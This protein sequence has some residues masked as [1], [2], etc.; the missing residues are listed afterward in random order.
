MSQ[1]QFKKK[2]TGNPVFVL[3]S[4]EHSK[5][6]ILYYYSRMFKIVPES[7]LFI[8]Y[9]VLPQTFEAPKFF[10]YF[11]IFHWFKSDIIHTYLYNLGA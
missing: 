8:I 1:H 3:E 6:R 9:I 11:D 5:T 2:P 10:Q 7:F 4:K